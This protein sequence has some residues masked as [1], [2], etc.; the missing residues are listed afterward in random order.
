MQRKIILF[1]L[2]AF[3]LIAN[4]GC[5]KKEKPI[6]ISLEKKEVLKEK[7]KPSYSNSM[8]I[9]VGGMI[10]PKEGFIYYKNLLEYIEEKTAKKID[11]VDRESYE[12]IY[13]LLK[14]GEIDAA[15]ICSGPYVDGKKDYGLE[16]IATPQAYGD[17]VYYSYFI[18]AKDSLI[19]SFDELRGKT[20][21]FT[22]PL[23][24]TGTLVPKYI[25]SKMN[26]TPDSFFKSYIFAQSHDKAIQAV[27]QRIVDGAAVDSLVWEYLNRTN[28][29]LTTKTRVIM[30]SPPYGI[31]PV[32]VR[33]GLDPETKKQLQHVLLTAHEDEKGKKILSNMM[34]D[35]FVVIDDRAYDSIRKMKAWVAEYNKKGKSK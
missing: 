1:I 8:R 32:V 23:S 11:F 12:D 4:A 31:P 34:I 18:V 29:D 16:L 9:A 21:A 35:R 33:P 7:T 30:K 2:I 25:L 28:P 14:I 19:K 13:N 6:M 15:F 10:T 26:E 22:D 20:F 17:T 24:N 3:G 5:E 27:V